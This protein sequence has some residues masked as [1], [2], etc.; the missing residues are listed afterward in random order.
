[1]EQMLEASTIGRVLVVGQD[2][3]LRGQLREALSR[4]EGEGES[5]RFRARVEAAPG[6]ATVYQVE[7]TADVQQALQMLRQAGN[8]SGP[9]DLVF[10]VGTLEFDRER[11]LDIVTRF[12]EVEAGLPVIL[13]VPAEDCAWVETVASRQY[14]HQLGVLRYPPDPLQARQLARAYAAR[15]RQGG[16]LRSCTAPPALV[17]A[18]NNLA[19]RPDQTMA[20]LLTLL[21]DGVGSILKRALDALKP[22]PGDRQDGNSGLAPALNHQRE[23]VWAVYRAATLVSQLS[24]LGNSELG[25]ADTMAE[26]DVVLDGT[27]RHLRHLLGDQ[28]KIEVE[29]GTSSVPVRGEAAAIQQLITDLALL[30]WHPLQQSG[31]LRLGVSADISEKDA[32]PNPPALAGTVSL[33]IEYQC[34]PNTPATANFTTSIRDTSVNAQGTGLEW[35]VAKAIVTRLG[36]RI[37]EHPSAN[38]SVG[39]EVSLPRVLAAS[40][41]CQSPPTEPPASEDPP[42]QTF[43]GSTPGKTVL[44][45]EDDEAVREVTRLVLQDRGCRI[46]EAGDSAEALR[47]WQENRDS[48]DLLIVDLVIPGLVD[49]LQLANRLRAERADLKVILTTGFAGSAFISELETSRGVEFLPKPFTYRQIQGVLNRCLEACPA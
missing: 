26:L 42:A 4:L 45:V 34:S 49:G 5:D 35:T 17:Q 31:T 3:A 38:G 19:E 11:G 36:G 2:G 20:T 23:L 15:S 13:C 40:R 7:E 48:L 21:A 6:A 12:W 37:R 9:Y 25:V 44:L 29:S 39:F 22:S 8:P 14:P 43:A 10:L 46:L 16:V 18:S 27:S 33:T 32:L 24:I 47:L 28:V 30:A 41:V 1:M